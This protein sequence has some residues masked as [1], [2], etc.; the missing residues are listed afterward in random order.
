MLP[1]ELAIFPLRVVLF[2][3][4]LLPLHIFEDRY[5]AMMRECI[6]RRAPFGVALSKRHESC[7]DMP[8]P[9][10]VGTSARILQVVYLDDGEMHMAVAGHERFRIV[11]IAQWEPYL[12]AIVR[13]SEETMTGAAHL[14]DLTVTAGG[15]FRDYLTLLLKLA[16]KDVPTFD[17]PDDPHVLSYSVAANMDISLP[18]KQELLETDSVCARLSRE[19]S[20]LRRET[21]KQ[22]AFLAVREK[23]RKQ[24]QKQGDQEIKYWLN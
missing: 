10:E 7:G 15:L 6:E 1:E 21:E 5:K 23:L 24:R 4:M 9:H 14:E 8:L 3:G 16:G 12:K 19:I 20:F 22:R 11:E 18:E 13:P 17:L 2:P